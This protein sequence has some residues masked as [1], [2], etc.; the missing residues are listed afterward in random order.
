MEKHVMH[1]ETLLRVTDAISQSKDPE[2]VVLLTTESVKLHWMSRDARSFSL[3]KKQKN[4]S[5]QP[6]LGLVKII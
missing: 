5:S 6:P 1:Y 4:W 3:I 2:E